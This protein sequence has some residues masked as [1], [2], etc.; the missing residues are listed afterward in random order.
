MP[1]VDLHKLQAPHGTLRATLS[2]LHC[3]KWS[4][5]L[6][7]VAM[8]VPQDTNHDNN[9]NSRHA[10]LAEATGFNYVRQSNNSP[11]RTPVT[12]TD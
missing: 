11:G 1:T 10:I 3:T 2:G 4:S 12:A 8:V 7:H 5:E 6:V 9:I